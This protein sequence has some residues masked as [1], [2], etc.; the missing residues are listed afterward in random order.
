MT[1]PS[2]ESAPEEFDRSLLFFPPG[3]LL[4]HNILRRRKANPWRWRRE[5]AQLFAPNSFAALSIT[6]ITSCAEFGLS[7]LGASG[8]FRGVSRSR[9]LQA[10]LRVK[11]YLNFAISSSQSRSNSSSRSHLISIPRK[12]ANLLRSDGDVTVFLFNPVLGVLRMLLVVVYY[13][14]RCLLA[15]HFRPADQQ[16]RPQW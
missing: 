4:Y 2:T 1:G 7:C 8:G 9:K 15:L 10:R 5:V 16:R 11:I 3:S 13:R 12:I 6:G 14:N